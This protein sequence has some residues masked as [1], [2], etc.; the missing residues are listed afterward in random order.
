MKVLNII[1]LE[2]GI[3]DKIITFQ[4]PQDATS[5]LEQSIVDKANER[6][7]AI[8]LEYG[9]EPEDLDDHLDSG[10]FSNMGGGDIYISWSDELG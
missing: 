4:I 10:N 3:L 5:I 2:C 6:F 9:A 8:A 7:K 1:I